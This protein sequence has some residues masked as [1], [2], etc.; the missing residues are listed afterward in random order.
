MYVATTSF[1]SKSGL[2][3]LPDGELAEVVACGLHQNDADRDRVLAR[4][5][6]ETPGK[7]AKR[8]ST[9]PRRQR[10]SR[11]GTAPRSA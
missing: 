6:L 5:I 9:P 8:R 3:F 7:R 1:S 11:P 4:R 2:S 10:A